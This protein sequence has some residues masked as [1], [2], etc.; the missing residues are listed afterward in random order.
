MNFTTT[1]Y[2]D[3]HYKSAD[4]NHP[5]PVNVLGEKILSYTVLS[6]HACSKSHA[7][8]NW[9]GRVGSPKNQPRGSC[10]SR[11]SPPPEVTVV[12]SHVSLQYLFFYFLLIFTGNMKCL[13]CNISA[14][15]RLSNILEYF[16]RYIHA[17]CFLDFY[18]L[19]SA[20]NF[21]RCHI[22]FLNEYLFKSSLFIWYF[23]LQ[24]FVSFICVPSSPF[25]CMDLPTFPLRTL[26]WAHSVTDMHFSD[27][28]IK[29]GCMVIIM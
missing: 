1:D 25:F 27:K 24:L 22:V 3:F 11:I 21:N 10:G 14:F 13:F 20:M 29:L 6:S 4:S 18:S 15:L 8:I 5:E 9:L 26:W 19:S 23:K 17:S 28:S 2:F 7:L 16:I 12:R